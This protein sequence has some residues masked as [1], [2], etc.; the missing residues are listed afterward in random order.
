MKREIHTCDICGQTISTYYMYKVK[1][2]VFHKEIY[3]MGD[4]YK[5]IC[6]ECWD[7]L[8]AMREAN[9]MSGRKENE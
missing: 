2:F 6:R 5:E 9:I 1:S 4:F 3:G 7:Q 8:K